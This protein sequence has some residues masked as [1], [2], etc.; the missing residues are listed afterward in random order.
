M[1]RRH[2]AFE[3]TRRQSHPGARQHRQHRRIPGDGRRWFVVTMVVSAIGWVAC[4]KRF[5]SIHPHS[6]FDPPSI[7]SRFPPRFLHPDSTPASFRFPRTPRFPTDSL[8]LP[9]LPDVLNVKHCETNTRY[10]VRAVAIT[11]DHYWHQ[12]S[13]A[14]AKKGMQTRTV[15]R[16]R[17]KAA[18]T[19]GGGSWRR[20]RW[21]AWLLR[22]GG[23]LSQTRDHP[24]ATTSPSS[25]G[26]FASSWAASTEYAHQQGLGG[27]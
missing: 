17:T 10:A 14:K 18:A 22:V 19:H 13:P 3:W 2:L 9:P 24:L 5:P 7:P 15:W 11:C 25:L 23:G 4:T 16:V 12:P 6:L 26:S 21:Y 20:C 8:S 27:A 1:R